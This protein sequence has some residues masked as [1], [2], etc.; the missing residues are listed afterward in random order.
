MI[1]NALIVAITARH[2][3]GKKLKDRTA[4]HKYMIEKYHERS[5]VNR[6]FR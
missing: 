2:S 3:I 5:I 6:Y 4:R 1:F